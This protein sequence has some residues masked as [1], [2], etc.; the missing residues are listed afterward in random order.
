M[1]QRSEKG[2]FAQMMELPSK[3]WE[4][5]DSLPCLSQA[6]IEPSK[7]E[8]KHIIKHVFTH[9]ELQL[10]LVE[11]EIESIKRPQ[12]ENWQWHAVSHIDDAAFPTLMRKAINKALLSI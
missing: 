1:R 7:G 8:R 5:E 9:F 10:E 4:Q 2:L 6:Q 11:I 3:G 12:I